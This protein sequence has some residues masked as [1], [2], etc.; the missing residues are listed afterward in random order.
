VN[1]IDEH[2]YGTLGDTSHVDYV[3]AD[4]SRSHGGSDSAG[5]A[6]TRTVETLATHMCLV[7]G[8]Q[9]LTASGKR[10]QTGEMSTAVKLVYIQWV[11][12]TKSW[13]P[14]QVNKVDYEKEVTATII[15]DTTF[16]FVS[17]CAD[18]E[19]VWKSCWTPATATAAAKPICG[20]RVVVSSTT[21][22]KNVGDVISAASKS[23]F[24]TPLVAYR[25]DYSY[26]YQGFA[27]SAPGSARGTCDPLSSSGRANCPT[28]ACYL[29]PTVTGMTPDNLSP[30]GTMVIIGNNFGARNPNCG[31]VVPYFA[32]HVLA[33]SCST[34]CSTVS[35]CASC[36]TKCEKDACVNKVIEWSNTRIEFKLASD[37]PSGRKEVKLALGGVANCADPP[38]APNNKQCKNSGVV[39]YATKQLT[40]VVFTKEITVQ[41]QGKVP[42]LFKFVSGT[43][44]AATLSWTTPES[45]M[46]EHYLLKWSA[47]PNDKQFAHASVVELEIVGSITSATIGGGALG[48]TV[49]SG[50]AATAL[51]IGKT[52]RVQVSARKNGLI[53]TATDIYVQHSVLPDAVTWPLGANGEAKPLTFVSYANGEVRAV[54]SFK[55]PQWNGGSPDAYKIRW[56]NVEN[57]TGT[58]GTKVVA[59]DL[60]IQPG[61]IQAEL[62]SNLKP[63]VQYN[64]TIVATSKA[65]R[66]EVSRWY[67]GIYAPLDRDE[68]PLDDKPWDQALGL[69][70]EQS[71]VAPWHVTE[72]HVPNWD[73]LMYLDT[74]EPKEEPFLPESEQH[75][76]GYLGNGTGYDVTLKWSAPA[77][78][79]N[80]PINDYKMEWLTY[81]QSSLPYT[82]NISYA[83]HFV[84]YLTQNDANLMGVMEQLDATNATVNVTAAITDWFNPEH[85]SFSMKPFKGS[86]MTKS[87]VTS[88][89]MSAAMLDYAGV[90]RIAKFGL[91]LCFSLR[92]QNDIGLSVAT[93]LRCTCGAGYYLADPIKHIC[94]PC[95]PNCDYCEPPL[96]GGLSKKPRCKICKLSMAV[97]KYS[98]TGDEVCVAQAPGETSNGAAAC[99]DGQLYMLRNPL[100]PGQGFYCV[101]AG[102]A[103]PNCTKGER[104]ASVTECVSCTLGKYSNQMGTGSKMTCDNCGLG[105]FTKEIKTTFACNNC[106]KGSFTSI[107]GSSFCDQCGPGK[108]SASEGLSTNDCTFCPVGKATNISGAEGC[109]DCPSGYITPRTGM[110]LC[111][112]CETGRWAQTTMSSAC[113]ECDEG[114]YSINKASI[115]W[116]CD[117]DLFKCG[118]GDMEIAPDLFS[119]LDMWFDVTKLQTH[120]HMDGT[121]TTFVCP[122]K[123]KDRV[124]E[125]SDEEPQSCEIC[126]TPDTC[127]MYFQT[128]LYPCLEEKIPLGE[129]DDERATTCATNIPKYDYSAILATPGVDLDGS[130]IQIE[131]EVSSNYF[132]AYMFETSWNGNAS[133]TTFNVTKNVLRAHMDLTLMNCTHHSMGVLCALCEEGY[134]RR[135][136]GCEPCAKAPSMLG[137]TQGQWLILMALFGA[138]AAIFV[139]SFACMRKSSQ[140]PKLYKFVH[141]LVVLK[142]F[143]KHRLAPKVK[144]LMENKRRREH[145]EEEL[146]DKAKDFD[147]T[148]VKVRIVSARH[149][150]STDVDNKSDPFVKVFWRAQSGHA[151][152]DMGKHTRVSANT[153]NPEWNQGFT[154]HTRTGIDPEV[155]LEVW[156]DDGFGGGDDPIGHVVYALD[157]S[158]PSKG[159]EPLEGAAGQLQANV[160]CFPFTDPPQ[161]PCFETKLATCHIISGSKM[162]RG[163]TFVK[164][165]TRPDVSCAWTDTASRTGS[166]KLVDTT[167]T[168]DGSFTF[169][170]VIGAKT[171]VRLVVC[172][173]ADESVLGRVDL[174]LVDEPMTGFHTV[175][176]ISSEAIERY[177]LD[178]SN[179]PVLRASAGLGSFVAPTLAEDNESM[180]AAAAAADELAALNVALAG[181]VKLPGSHSSETRR[182]F[183]RGVQSVALVAG[184]AFAISG[185]R[186]GG[187]ASSALE[188]PDTF[189]GD[190]LSSVLAAN[191]EGQMAQQGGEADIG[192]IEGEN[193]ALSA[194]F[195]EGAGNTSDITDAMRGNAEASQGIVD[196]MVGGIGDITENAQGIFASI[197]P[198]IKDGIATAKELLGVLK[199]IYDPI[200][201]QWKVL[202]GNLQIL[203]SMQ[204]CLGSVPWPESYLNLLDSLSVLKFDVFVPIKFAAP[205]IDIT[206]Y[207]G[208]VAFLLVPLFAVAGMIAAIIFLGFFNLFMIFCCKPCQTRPGCR[209]RRE[210]C[211][212]KACCIDEDALKGTRPDVLTGKRGRLQKKQKHSWKSANGKLRNAEK[213]CP[214]CCKKDLDWSDLPPMSCHRGEVWLCPLKFEYMFVFEKLLITITLLLYPG[215]CNKCFLLLQC[216][217]ISGVKYLTS[218]YSQVCDGPDGPDPQYTIYKYLAFAGI[219]VYIAGLP[220]LILTRLLTFRCFSGARDAAGNRLSLLQRPST[221]MFLKDPYSD[222]IDAREIIIAKNQI[223]KQ[224]SIEMRYGS[225]YDSYE[226]EYWFFEIITILRKL[227]LTGVIVLLSQISELVQLLTAILVCVIYLVCVTSFQPFIDPRDD[228]LAVA[229][230]LQMLLTMIIAMALSLDTGE[231]PQTTTFLGYVL[232][233]LTVAVIGLALYQLPLMDLVTYI[234]DTFCGCCK[235]CG[236]DEDDEEDD[237]KKKKKKKKCSCGRSAPVEPEPKL[238]DAP[239]EFVQFS[240]MGPDTID[241]V[242][243]T[244]VEAVVVEEELFGEVDATAAMMDTLAEAEAFLLET[245]PE[246]VDPPVSYEEASVSSTAEKLGS[247]DEFGQ[248]YDLA[249]SK[250]ERK[251]SKRTALTSGLKSARKKKLEQL[252]TEDSVREAREGFHAARAS[253]QLQLEGEQRAKEEKT[254]RRLAQRRV[255]QM[256]KLRKRFAA[257]DEDGSGSISTE[258]LLTL[259]PEDMDADAAAALVTRFDADGSGEIDDEEFEALM[260]VSA[261]ES[262]RCACPLV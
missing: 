241:K 82:Y 97:R 26:N 22:S 208:V 203:G 214:M 181:G 50:N 44:T 20:W 170:A 78:D 133:K 142:W 116:E 5:P 123:M 206:F 234:F 189:I 156:D 146:S 89:S 194:I 40:S 85:V 124:K 95:T 1:V 190:S 119:G 115:C 207:D 248:G 34:S 211:A 253:S 233:G 200:M 165:L 24:A 134:T 145:G 151:W 70:A 242:E 244:V 81:N 75:G 49:V 215:L 54:A 141:T 250:V 148:H 224:Q 196:G 3:N 28:Y 195:G 27:W 93:P 79:G 57:A 108:F 167:A 225:L 32:I 121:Q 39:V 199:A 53:G 252:S 105:K 240:S 55:C 2:I 102:L 42:R 247:G 52:Y 92:A 125:L 61:Q 136:F 226:D 7:E 101:P 71:F 173:S 179:L 183:T 8:G 38:Q 35:E 91:P 114:K 19:K 174:T 130:L 127:T 83:T 229:E 29:P 232:I 137:L 205:C 192:D 90:E 86:A 12:A 6:G 51:V 223:I 10:F 59:A 36:L 43:T 197:T 246:A 180:R 47:V 13:T 249:S 69:E 37:I 98:S 135:D 191:F 169:T 128:A 150:L 48:H 30:D 221:S 94:R 258:E 152:V 147:P 23:S 209:Q 25:T 16:T 58:I 158:G 160:G 18:D 217:E 256:A 168:W 176:G 162:P 87:V 21:A 66:G 254:R 96:A 255:K 187:V 204:V 216:Q 80:A 157:G 218:D 212:Y 74:A 166:A 153:L 172:S 171:T 60:K 231:D 237:T 99:G 120:T 161:L 235:C 129:G 257:L 175:V 262:M 67:S 149:L 243:G 213:L 31:L 14:L 9:I 140:D 198:L 106:Q 111:E 239:T 15:D 177:N 184:A 88:K 143:V 41:D 45:G 251:K 118:K 259:L 107:T 84:E 245:A 11:D 139:I 219:V 230:A 113:K 163:G 236:D 138:S 72:P 46:P 17:P 238:A 103:N 228:R 182:R 154:F 164:L 188:Q 112:G 117:T 144:R 227:M 100:Q 155:K 76:F 110:P 159:W 65:V 210:K 56:F 186:A 109:N 201:S 63:R 62:I 220:L 77:I 222:E 68:P 122:G 104:I 132:E 4:G 178:P 260:K 261:G 126:P 202:L 64:F 185:D 73:V 131:N 193:E 33:M